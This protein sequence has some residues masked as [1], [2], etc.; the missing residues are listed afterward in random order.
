M[1]K[2]PRN[3]IRVL[4]DYPGTWIDADGALHFDVPAIHQHLGLPDTPETRE[5][6]TEM[7]AAMLKKMLPPETK[8]IVR[9]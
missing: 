6:T 7:L 2:N 4:S 8:I 9:E 1:E 3:L 5:E